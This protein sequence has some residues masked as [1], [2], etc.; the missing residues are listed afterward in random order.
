MFPFQLGRKRRGIGRTP[1]G[2]EPESEL[3]RL[4]FEEGNEEKHGRENSR[5]RLKLPNVL[6]CIL[7]YMF[8]LSLFF[9]LLVCISMIFAK[10]GT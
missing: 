1:A 3:R 9:V 10:T 7:L 5:F 4:P 8:I 2:L 6:S